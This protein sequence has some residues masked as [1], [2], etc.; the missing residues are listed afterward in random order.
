[1][2]EVTRFETTP[3]NDREF[4]KA[5]GSEFGPGRRSRRASS[6]GQQNGAPRRSKASMIM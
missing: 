2:G 6:K 4:A 1:M 5:Y 3:E